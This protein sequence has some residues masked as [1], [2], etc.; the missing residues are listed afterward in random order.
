MV[1][2]FRARST[3]SCYNEETFVSL[4]FDRRKGINIR[5]NFSDFTPFHRGR[6]TLVRSEHERVCK[7]LVKTFLWDVYEGDIF[8]LRIIQTL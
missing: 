1:S 5:G 6:I 2:S 3:F 7:L 4:V 8:C